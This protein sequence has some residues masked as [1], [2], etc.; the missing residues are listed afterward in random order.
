MKHV[1]QVTVAVLANDLDAVPVWVGIPGDRVGQLIIKAGPATATVEL[2]TGAIE[3]RIAP[4][5]EKG[6]RL[7]PIVVFARERPLGPSVDDHIMF[8]FGE[9]VIVV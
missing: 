7:L 5:A 9:R 4:P 8:F 3:G 2:I 6:A 1:P